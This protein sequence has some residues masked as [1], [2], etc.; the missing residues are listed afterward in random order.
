M[1]RFPPSLQDQ[2][3]TGTTNG[4]VLLIENSRFYAGML[5][6]ELRERLGVDVVAVASL[7]AAREALETHA[8]TPFFLA[9]TGLVLPDAGGDQITGLLIAHRV[10]TVVVTGVYDETARQRLAEQP[11]I[12]YVLK[13]A[14]GNIDY[15]VWL[16][17][18]IERNRGITALVVDDLAETRAQVADLLD[19]YGFRVRCAADAAAGLAALSEDASIRLIVLEHDL[20]DAD[21][22]EFIRR[23]RQAHARDMLSIVGTSAGGGP[24][25]VARFLKHGA[26]DFVRKPFSREEFFCRI[27]QNVDNLELIGTLQDL[28]TRD[29]LTGL[30]NRRHFF[31]QGTRALAR[32]DAPMT[33]AMLDLDRFKQINDH[34]GHDAGD[35]ALRAVAAAVAQHARA[36]DLVAR[37]GG[38]EFCML[39][40]EQSSEAAGAS[41]EALREAIAELRITYKQHTI[42]V[43][44]SIGVCHRRDTDLHGMLTDADRLLYLAKAR[45]RNRVVCESWVPA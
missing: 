23:A 16:V 15:L 30:P 7:A 14:P 20:P 26:N 21:G 43:T 40:T 11:I 2:V 33:V 31:D 34:Y 8:A 5:A 3:G 36:G 17:R 41:L 29:Y 25:L 22:I 12:D 4:R 13:D 38:E 6:S 35:A 44:V 19:L 28:A 39:A 42:R 18:R 45:G 24:S 37:F 10:P 1:T 32:T 27:S 9:L